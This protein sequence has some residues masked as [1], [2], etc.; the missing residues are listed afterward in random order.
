MAE[1]L[2]NESDV[3]DVYTSKQA[4]EDGILF[5]LKQ[6]KIG[7]EKTGINYITSNL[8]YSKGYLKDGELVNKANFID[9]VNQ[10]IHIIKSKPQD[11]FYSGRI[12]LPSGEKCEIFIQQ[13][14]TGKFTIMLPEDR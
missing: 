2:F 11:Y 12:E 7:L 14:E 6:L 3:I 10:A 13:N 9:L 4:V 1:Q 8:C 5:D